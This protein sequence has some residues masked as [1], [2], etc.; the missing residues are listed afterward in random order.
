MLVW[1]IVMRSNMTWVMRKN[2]VL[3][4]CVCSND[5]TFLKVPGELCM[6]G[7]SPQNDVMLTAVYNSPP[8]RER[9]EE[10]MATPMMKGS[11]IKSEP[12][13]ADSPWLP[14]ECQATVVNSGEINRG[15]SDAQTQ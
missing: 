4:D 5:C 9:V 7:Q 15:R 11:F 1:I 8:E 10:T 3:K 14:T 6:E 13:L 2:I 12:M